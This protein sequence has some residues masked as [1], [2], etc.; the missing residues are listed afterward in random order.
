MTVM[1]RILEGIA[2]ALATDDDVSNAIW[3]CSGVSEA[4]NFNRQMKP[5]ATMLDT[6][7]GPRSFEEVLP[8]VK[9]KLP[10]KNLS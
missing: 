2:L 3:W 7:D 4:L 5:V 9:R 1:T 8:A 6:A 10:K